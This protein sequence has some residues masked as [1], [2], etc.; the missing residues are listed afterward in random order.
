[1]LINDAVQNERTLS[2]IRFLFTTTLVEGKVK[3]RVFSGS[4]V[5]SRKNKAVDIIQPSTK[6]IWRQGSKSWREG[7][8]T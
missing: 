3:Q 8:F 7:S 6:N 2:N 4:T 5:M 1:M